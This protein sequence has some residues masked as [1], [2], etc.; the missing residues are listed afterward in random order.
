[1]YSF[2]DVRSAHA[3]EDIPGCAGRFRLHV[4]LP[5]RSPLDL[6]G[7]GAVAARLSSPVCRDPIEVV[8]PAGGGALLSYRRADG[9]YVH[10]LNSQA[11]LERKLAQFE[12][13]ATFAD[14]PREAASRED[15][16]GES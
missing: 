2:E 1:M 14:K 8:F 7:P 15:R 5:G 16:N 9:S 11:G 13:V 6:A 12:L 3:W 4:P 10:T